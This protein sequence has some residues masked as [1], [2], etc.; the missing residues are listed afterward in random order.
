MRGT[1]LDIKGAVKLSVAIIFIEMAH[2][3]SSI[4]APLESEEEKRAAF[5]REINERMKE[6]SRET[7][8]TLARRAKEA[9]R[10][11]NLCQAEEAVKRRRR[12]ADEERFLWLRPD[13][14]VK[15]L[16][17]PFYLDNGTPFYL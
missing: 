13:F 2:Q 14:V 5:I 8:K 4:E 12:E 3:E 17:G 7:R 6:R 15:P 16:D 9:E 11:A 10:R 1:L